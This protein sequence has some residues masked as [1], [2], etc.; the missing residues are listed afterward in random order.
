MKEIHG[1]TAQADGDE[2]ETITVNCS[3][4]DKYNI[5][6]SRYLNISDMT[7]RFKSWT[8][9]NYTNFSLSSYE[10]DT[11]DES[12]DKGD[13][14]SDNRNGK[15]GSNNDVTRLIMST[16]FDRRNYKGLSKVI[17]L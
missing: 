13:E 12:N 2:N 7:E 14:K 6:V 5:V 10:T 8:I 3:R 16:V 17:N 4:G 1:Y 11:F 9:T 15:Q